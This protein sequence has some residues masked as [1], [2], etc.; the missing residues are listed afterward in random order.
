MGLGWIEAETLSFN[1]LLLMD[2]WIVRYISRRRNASFN[3]NLGI[4]LAANP[5]V[6]WYFC[7]RCPDCREHYEALA[8][9][10]ATGLSDE[11]VRKCE[12]A[13][14][15]SLETFTV[16]LYPEIM[17]GLPYITAWS[18]ERLLSMT[19]FTD[20]RV[21]DIGSGT[22]RLAIAAAPLARWVYACEP[23]DRLR[24]YMRDKLERLGVN[25]VFVVDGTIEKLPFPDEAFDV[26]VSGHVIGDD[27]DREC[28]EM[29]RVTVPGG[30]IISCPGEDDRKEPDGPI[31]EMLD[32]GYDYSHYVSDL[33]G[34][35]YRYWKTRA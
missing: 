20:K 19:D 11:E 17:D 7:A 26:V 6:C 33:D 15:D 14:L 25:N 10:A 1:T 27:F 8:S 31:Q 23:V 4:A 29:E 35:V 21:L 18:P 28:R 5:A 30:I 13:V 32:R 34:D 3:Q 16:Y 22:G 24:E 12:V 2:A 9:S